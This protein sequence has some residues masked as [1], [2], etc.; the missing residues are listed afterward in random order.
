M[1]TEEKDYNIVIEYHS[2]PTQMID[3]HNS[4][5]IYLIGINERLFND[6]FEAIE[7]LSECNDPIT[8]IE[9]IIPDIKRLKNLKYVLPENNIKIK[10]KA[11]SIQILDATFDLES[12]IWDFHEL[13]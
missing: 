3:D 7:F 4:D 1:K 11:M 6:I 10:H 2:D 12:G 5:N 8:Q 13:A 9:D